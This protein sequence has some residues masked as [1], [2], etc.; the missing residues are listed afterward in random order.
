L[1]KIAWRAGAAIAGVEPLNKQFKWPIKMV[2][3][4]Q[5]VSSHIRQFVVSA[6]VSKKIDSTGRRCKEQSCPCV[7]GLGGG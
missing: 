6:M 5:P 4:N 1:A 3:T 7:I 2:L